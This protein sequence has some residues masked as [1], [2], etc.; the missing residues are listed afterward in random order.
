MYATMDASM[1][2]IE[3]SSGD[4]LRDYVKW[5][6][7][8][9]TTTWNVDPVPEKWYAIKD[10]GG[11]LHV[12]TNDEASLS[13]TVPVI[14]LRNGE[15]G[16]KPELN[17]LGFTNGKLTQIY[18]RDDE[19]NA[20]II[21]ASDLQ[22][23]MELVPA[24][25]VEGIVSTILPASESSFT[26]TRDNV[27]EINLV[28]TDISNIPDIQD[29]DDD[30]SAIGFK[31]VVSDIYG[32]NVDITAQATNPVGKLIDIRLAK[33]EPA[34]YTGQELKPV[35]TYDGKT[36]VEGVDYVLEN[37]SGK[38]F[39]EPGK[40]DVTVWGIGDYVEFQL[41]TFV[42]NP[43]DEGTD[44]NASAGSFQVVT[45]DGAPAIGAGNMADVA[46]AVLTQDE[47]A[48]GFG[49]LLVSSPYTEAE[50]PK[51]D[52]AALADL[53]AARG[54]TVGAWFDISLYKTSGDE[55]I[56]LT[57]APT[58]VKLTVEVPESLRKDGRTFFLLHCHNGQA[59]VVAEG[60]GP[61]L[62]WEADKFSTCAIAY[63]DTAPTAAAPAKPAATAKTGDPL[64]PAG[65]A[66]MLTAIATGAAAMSVARKKM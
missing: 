6:N 47:I 37:D 4:F 22:T 51:D 28:Y 59:T 3:D 11:N 32:A 43:A 12:A 33:V 9:T 64:L 63:K 27:D 48:A 19:G 8:A 39:V 42:I 35:V 55:R 36:L 29:V 26:V 62:S 54:A 15:I 49:L 46:N 65:F 38:P 14:R 7:D 34:T 18:L 17:L 50:V 57:E 40:Y 25:Y 30:G 21:R 5:F 56:K 2:T 58:P 52:K 66:L 60:E 61:S 23:E 20:R 45:A 31:Y 53:A 41:G 16:D 44:E 1:D 24:L 10:A 13:A